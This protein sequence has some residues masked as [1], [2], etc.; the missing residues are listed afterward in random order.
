[1]EKASTICYLFLLTTLISVMNPKNVHVHGANVC[2]LV[3]QNT[4]CQGEDMGKI[5]LPACQNRCGVSVVASCPPAPGI[6]WGHQPPGTPTCS[7]ET[8]VD[9]D[10]RTT[11]PC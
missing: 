5:C 9:G 7:C 11:A 8:I 10:C 3:L 1:M 4:P 6:P 2:Y